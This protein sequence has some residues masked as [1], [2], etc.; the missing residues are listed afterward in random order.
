MDFNTNHYVKMNLLGRTV[1][2]LTTDALH[3]LPP[4]DF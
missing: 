2:I 4:V 1:T 3:N